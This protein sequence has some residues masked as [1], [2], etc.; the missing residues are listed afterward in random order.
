[1][2]GLGKSSKICAVSLAK[3]NGIGSNMLFFSIKE[4][5]ISKI[6]LKDI[7]SGQTNSII[8]S[9]IS[10]V[11]ILVIALVK[12]EQKIGLNFVLPL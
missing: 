4:S 9:L 1:M 2:S 5:S 7:S 11:I 12:S 10:P 3:Q 6:S 8:F